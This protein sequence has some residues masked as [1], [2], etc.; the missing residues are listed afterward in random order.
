MPHCTNRDTVLMGHYI[1]KR[2]MVMTNIYSA[3]MDPRYWQGPTNFNPDRFI[4]CAGKL[5]IN[6]ALVPFSVGPRACLGEP[7]ARIELFLVITKLL[8]RFTVTKSDPGIKYSM[9]SKPNQVT[10]APLPYEVIFKER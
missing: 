6:K 2:T 3:T 8:Q 1:P 5:I 4:N 7:L 10:R 9:D